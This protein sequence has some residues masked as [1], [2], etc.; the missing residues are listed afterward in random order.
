L[1]TQTLCLERL[2]YGF[3]THLRK[4]VQYPMA[5]QARLHSY[6]FGRRPLIWGSVSHQMADFRLANLP[7]PSCRELRIAGG[8]V[9][10]E[11]VLVPWLREARCQYTS[12][13]IFQIDG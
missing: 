6:G 13:T 8:D 5:D 4:H 9:K 10:K 2:E 7:P 1:V 12:G 11:R 3:K